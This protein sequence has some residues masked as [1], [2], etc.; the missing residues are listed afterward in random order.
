MST[1][2]RWTGTRSHSRALE[3]EAA[4]WI[5]TRMKQASDNSLVNLNNRR[6]IENRRP[7][8]VAHRGGVVATNSPENSLNAIRDAGAHPYDMV[9]LD[10]AETKDREPVLFHGWNGHLGVDCG[11]NAFVYELNSEEV[12]AIKYRESDQCIINLAQALEVC[13]EYE[14]GV[15]LDLKSFGPDHSDEYSLRI[16]DLVGAYELSEASL[17]FSQDPMAY[18]HLSE[19]IKFALSHRELH[20]LA[21]G[22]LGDVEGRWVFSLPNDAT[23]D[24]LAKIQE[25]GCILIVAINRFRYPTHAHQLMAKKDIDR[26]TKM[27]VNGFQIDSIYA[28][29]LIHKPLEIGK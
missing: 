27:G 5:S 3:A 9:E 2:G 25:S 26:L 20:L 16:A 17:T 19:D 14:L 18:E 22:E 13:R 1:T 8:L 15:M 24:L 29:F 21:E 28:R 7:L 4:S 12:A 23:T 10:V 11:V 6:Q